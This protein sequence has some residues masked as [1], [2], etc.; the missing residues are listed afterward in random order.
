[1]WHVTLST[2]RSSAVRNTG[3]INAALGLFVAVGLSYCG[4]DHIFLRFIFFFKIILTLPLFIFFAWRKWSGRVFLN[5]VPKALRV[6]L[7]RR[8][9]PTIKS[10]LPRSHFGLNHW[11]KR[12]GNQARPKPHGEIYQDGASRSENE[13]PTH[14]KGWCKG[15][16]A[17]FLFSSDWIS[18]QSTDAVSF[19]R[20][21][22]HESYW[23]PV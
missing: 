3:S 13:F 10:A 19:W 9:F 11:Q 1:M 8:V 2:F 21:F 17:P 5:F 20:R 15:W 12:L 18:L 14:A 7:T 6:S 16:Y 22:G 23:W 4:E